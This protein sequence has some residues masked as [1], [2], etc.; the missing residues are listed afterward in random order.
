MRRLTLQYFYVAHLV[1][2]E[3]PLPVWIANVTVACMMHLITGLV[4]SLLSNTVINM[5]AE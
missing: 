1:T 2:Q 5:P 3:S 4:L